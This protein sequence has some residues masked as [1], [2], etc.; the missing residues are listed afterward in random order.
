MSERTEVLYEPPTL[1]EAGDF[2]E[3]TR[4]GTGDF[5]EPIFGRFNFPTSQG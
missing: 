3:M 2:T 1:T 5:Q 4:G